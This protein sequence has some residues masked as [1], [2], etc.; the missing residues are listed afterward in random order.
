MILISNFPQIKQ[1]SLWWRHQMETYSALL[2]LCAGTSPVTGEFPAQ[3][4]VTRSFDVSFICAWING[5]ANNRETGETQSRSL[6]RHRNV[7]PYP[8]P[9][10]SPPPCPVSSRP[11]RCQQ[12]KR[13]P[14]GCGGHAPWTTLS[15]YRFPLRPHDVRDRLTN[16]CEEINTSCI[17]IQIFNSDLKGANVRSIHKQAI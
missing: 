9:W 6:W 1:C 17:N 7:C 10:Q 4:P 16:H 2:A 3:R 15:G 13:S 12:T 5:W 14:D 8:V 11:V